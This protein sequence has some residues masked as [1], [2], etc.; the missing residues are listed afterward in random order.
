MRQPALAAALVVHF[1]TVEAHKSDPAIPAE[2]RTI[3]TSSIFL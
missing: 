3:I 2:D 1:A